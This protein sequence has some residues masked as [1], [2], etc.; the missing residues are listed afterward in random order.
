MSY[1]WGPDLHGS[2][3]RVRELAVQRVLAGE[4]PFSVAMLTPGVTTSEVVDWVED[5]RGNADAAAQS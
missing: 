4:A 1:G 3:E 2:R 5:A